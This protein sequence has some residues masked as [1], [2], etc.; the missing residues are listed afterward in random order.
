M[1]IERK[2]KLIEPV[3]GK[4]ELEAITNVL[5]S[6]WLTE[7]PRTKE[8]ENK[9]AEY[10]VAKYA[11]ATCNCTVAIELCLKALN[12]K[13]EVIIPDFT[14]PATA[15]AVY[16]AGAT[17]VL[18]DVDINTYNIDVNAIEQAITAKT[19]AIIPVSWGGNPLNNEVYKEFKDEFS[20]IEDAACSLGSQFND[21]KTGTLADAT[22]FS[23]HPRKTMTTGEGGMITTNNENL[24][25]ILRSL[26]CFGESSDVIL[27]QD[28]KG[29]YDYLKWCKG[30]VKFFWPHGTN[31]KISD[32]LS[33][34]GLTQMKKID[35]IINRRIEMAENYNELLEDL[36][37]VRTP[38]KDEKAKHTYQTYAI[39]LEKV[40]RDMVIAKLAEKGIET[41][42]GTY[43]LHT[44][45]AFEHTPKSGKLANSYLL[46]KKLLALPMC[47]SMSFQDQEYVVEQIKKL[48]NK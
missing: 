12:V 6:G 23:F 11:I 37:N 2:F 47:H 3:V 34:I 28:W 15:N 7:G 43:A 40:D 36:P 14:H 16:N 45:P 22:C 18:V 25:K 35:T 19:D 26:K 30:K 17:P 33:A 5:Q 21:E 48:L 39:Y 4:E 10:V 38:H 31:Y 32:V 13:G 24:M 44:Q 9:V 46:Y 8:F 20:I 42:I 1:T 27:T 29:S 41:Q